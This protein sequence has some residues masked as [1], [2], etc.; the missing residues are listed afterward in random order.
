MASVGVTK[1]TQGTAMNGQK[2]TEN[3]SFFRKVRESIRTV[4][5]KDNLL[6]YCCSMLVISFRENPKTAWAKVVQARIDMDARALKRFGRRLGQ[7]ADRPRKTAKGNPAIRISVLVPLYNT[8][9]GFLEEMIRSVQA[10]TWPNWELCLA[11][12][13]DEHHP[14]V[15]ETCERLAAEDPRIR[16][17]KLEENKGISENTNACI[18]LATGNYL[19]LLDH[20]DLLHPEALAEAAKAIREEGADFI[21]TDEV[22]FDSPDKGKLITTHFKP[23]YAPDNLLT[24]NYICHLSVFKVSLLEKAGRFRPA[25]DGSQDYDIILRLTDC[26]EQVVHVPRA[27]Y[28]WRSHAAST[29]SGIGAKSFAAEAGK[30]ALEDF[31]RNRKGLEVSVESAPEYPTLYHVSYPVEESDRVDLILDLT[32]KTDEEIQNTLRAVYDRTAW[33]R[34]SVTVISDAELAEVPMPW[35]VHRVDGRGKSRPKRLNEAAEAGTGAFLV[36]LDATLIPENRDWLREMVMLAR[37][38]E[39]GAVSGKSF[40]AD[41]R[42]RHGGLIL[43]LG[44][45]GLAGRACFRID[46]TTGGYF[47]QLAVVEDFSIVSGECMAVSREKFSASGGF[48]PDYLDTLFDADLCLKLRKKGY[49]NLFTPYARFRG[50]NAADYCLDYG[51]E[52]KAYRTDGQTFRAKWKTVLAKP[53]P[54]YN[55]NLT[56]KKGNYNVG[57]QAKI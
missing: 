29:A 12:G 37:R 17:R 9:A 47:G 13:S 33:E 28:F 51:R 50:G 18:D 32:G 2:R 24:N 15:R 20:D 3:G 38:E 26:A 42:I 4:A 21:Y 39:I 23:D 1:K 19:A 30:T 36:F 56:E 46:G 31:L 22:V 25:C 5:R 52:S 55:P 45:N 10:Q 54:C 40:L 14:E 41:G 57:K 48:D 49:R 7:S 27:L 34:V 8:P 53:D 44:K 11:D 43:R 16:Y 35:P 6:G